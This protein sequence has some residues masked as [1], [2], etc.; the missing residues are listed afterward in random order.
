MVF[1]QLESKD[2]SLLR[3]I[4]DFLTSI[5]GFAPVI[6]LGRGIFQYSFGIVPHR[7]DRLKNFIPILPIQ[8]ADHTGGGC[9]NS[10]QADF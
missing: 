1:S 7:C 2:G 8:K 5:A 10:R 6:F 4:Q 9:P 3:S